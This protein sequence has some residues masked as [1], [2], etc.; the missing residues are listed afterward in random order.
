MRSPFRIAALTALATLLSAAPPE[1]AP[2]R[3]LFVVNYSHLD[4]QWRW[5]YPLVVREMLRNTLY[6]NFTQMEA[7]PD[8]VFNWTGAGRYQLFQEYYPAEYQRLK[9]Y[10]AKGQWFPSGNAW[11]ESDANVPSSEALIRQLLVGHTFFKREFGT[12]SSEFMLPD[13]FGFP[14]SLP[15]IL[16]HCGLKGFST[17]KL[18]WGSAN[19]VPFNVGRWEGPDGRSIVAALN[20]GAY[21][22][23]LLQPL[24]G[25]AW[26][27]RLDENG[28]KGGLKVDYLYNGVGDEGGAPFEDSL[29]TVR[30]G[31]AAHG[32]VKIV[33]GRADLMFNAIT[34]EQKAKLPG[35]QG[36]LLLTEHSAGSITSAAFMKQLNRRNELLADGAEKASTAALLLGAAPYPAATLE[37]AW[38]LMLRNQFHDMLPGTCLPKSYEYAWNDGFIAAKAFSASLT[39]GVGAVARGLDT[40]V[41][42][43]PLVVY[44]PLGIQR[45]DV[46]EVLVPAE[47]AQA[48][49]LTALDPA[50]KPLPTQLTTGPDGLRRV[51]FSAKVPSVGFAVYGLRAGHA[52]TGA[53]SLKTAARIVEN[54]HYRV[55][56]NEGGDLAS[57]FDKLNSRELLSAPAR[58][59]FQQEQPRRWPAWNMDWADRQKA[60]RAFVAGPARITV[61]EEGPVRV[62]IQVDRESEGSTFRQTVR[63]SAGGDRVEVANLI[64]WKSSEASLK[65]AFPLAV[66]NPLATYSWDLGTVQRGNND[67]KKYEVPSHGWFDLTDAKGEYGVTVLTGAKYGS[68]KPD[69]HTLRL[70]L[71]YT[72]G[73]HGEYREQRWQDW[74]RH[75]FV[76][77]LAGHA[78]DWRKSGSRWLAQRQD[79]PLEAFAVAAHPGPLGKTFSLFQ[80]G[81][82]QVAIQAV[83]R[84]EDGQ[85]VVVRLQELHGQAV[86]AMTLKAAGT[87]LEARELDGLERPLGEVKTHKGALTLAFTP[88][89]IRTLGLRIA[90]PTAIAAPAGAPLALPFNLQAFTTDDHREDGAMDGAFTSYPAEMIGDTL[91]AAGV[92]FRMGPRT[93][94]SRNA[95]ACQGQVLDLPQGTRSVHLLVAASETT[96]D[97][98]FK[99][100]TGTV[101][102]T[103][104]AWTGVQGSWDNRIFKGEVPELTYSVDNAL[105]RISPAFLAP[106]RPVWWASHHHAKGRDQI[107]AYSYLFTLRLDVPEGARTLTLPT[108]G[109]VKVFAATTA[110]IDNAGAAPMEALFPDLARDAAFGVK[111]S[112]P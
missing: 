9:S 4:T 61:T 16:A 111:F 20:P 85:S 21:D 108:D 64:D 79:Q 48:Q 51:L 96:V 10:V 42:G 62:A 78:G 73:V 49:A 91:E 32:P 44:N 17:G 26:V 25:E 72:P 80:S 99:L 27:K 35:Y 36:D 104:P 7:H 18:T 59:A 37:K 82:P 57:V 38:G 86:P 103:V 53:S 74:G 47:L 6:D 93:P 110:T 22:E 88:N 87:I 65:A 45:E 50:G 101:T 105:E 46:V 95:V 41:D 33:A 75:A 98:A 43:V 77:G 90:A 52:P 30:A 24:N 19:G 15:S 71:L 40:R 2:D 92:T 54:A 102:R 58:L 39:D 12:E 68:D 14:A 81:S 8:Y 34:P 76:Y 29:K 70:T 55:T 5:G 28:R 56:L 69:D 107:Y 60:P 31:M 23:H 1:Q 66:A 11:E 94:G 63:L 67:P 100:G 3:T 112:K 84:S 13:C 83:K 89:Q 109:R 97:A 106:G